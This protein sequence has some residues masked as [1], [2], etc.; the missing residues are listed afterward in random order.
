MTGAYVTDIGD[1]DGDGDLDIAASGYRGNNIV[2]Y[3]N[4]HPVWNKHTIAKNLKVSGAVSI[5]DIDGD[6]TLDIVSSGYRQGGDVVWYENNHP[7][8]T[9]HTIRSNYGTEWTWVGDIDGDGAIDV[10]SSSVV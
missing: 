9:K 1:L 7:I 8:W 6:D 2:W 5:A 10:S 4:N 3:E